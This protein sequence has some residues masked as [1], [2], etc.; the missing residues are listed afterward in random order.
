[1]GRRRDFDVDAH[2][3]P[4]PYICGWPLSLQYLQ[5]VLYLCAT[6]LVPWGAYRG[7]RSSLFVLGERAPRNKGL[8]PIG[9]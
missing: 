4:F 9:Q 3:H 1:M 5:Y 7:S 2:I 8:G 6:C